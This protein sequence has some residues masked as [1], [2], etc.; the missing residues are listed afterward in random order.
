L[1]LVLNEREFVVYKQLKINTLSIKTKNTEGPPPT[2]IFCFLS[3]KKLKATKPSQ[4]P[5]AS[6]TEPSAPDPTLQ[7][8]LHTTKSKEYRPKVEKPNRVKA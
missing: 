7:Y 6:P 2:S 3:K 5:P 4:T 8:S 1:A